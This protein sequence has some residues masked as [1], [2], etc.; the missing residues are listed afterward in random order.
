[1]LLGMKEPAQTAYIQR[2]NCVHTAYI[3]EYL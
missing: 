3:R 2:T 1:M